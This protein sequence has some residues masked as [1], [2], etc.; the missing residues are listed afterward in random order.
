VKYVGERIRHFPGRCEVAVEIHLAV[1]RQEAGEDQAVEE[2]RLPVGGEARVKID[3][4]G[5]DE[6]GEVAAG[7]GNG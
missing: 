3:G 4:V 5:F 7:E 6:K 1:A 2:L